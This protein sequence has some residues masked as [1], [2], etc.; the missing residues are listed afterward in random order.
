MNKEN[1]KGMCTPAGLGQVPQMTVSRQIYQEFLMSDH[2]CAKIMSKS[3]SWKPYLQSIN[4][5]FFYF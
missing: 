4:I 2:C 3:S 5:H 1:I